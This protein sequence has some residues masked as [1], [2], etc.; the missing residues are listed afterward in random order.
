MQSSESRQARPDAERINVQSL[1]E[2]TLALISMNLYDKDDYFI[3]TYID[4]HFTACNYTRSF[5][6]ENEQ[7]A[8]AI[9]VNIFIEAFRH[10]VSDVDI[11]IQD[12]WENTVT[13][14]DRF[15]K[16]FF[17]DSNLENDDSRSPASAHSAASPQSPQSPQSIKGGRRVRKSRRTKNSRIKRSRKNK[18]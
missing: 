11:Y 4:T 13:K 10:D 16:M 5:T 6:R 8:K 2:E 1:D 14:D 15:K 18:Y 7:S 17:S 3:R 12:E 9:L